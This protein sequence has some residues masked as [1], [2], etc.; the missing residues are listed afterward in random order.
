VQPTP[1][2][3]MLL[4]QKTVVKYSVEPAAQIPFGATQ[5]PPRKSAFE[6]VLYEIIGGLAIATHQNSRETA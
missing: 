4:D 1:P 6:R 2:R 5:V 3:S